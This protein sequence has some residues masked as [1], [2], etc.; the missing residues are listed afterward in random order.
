M[1]PPD[2]NEVMHCCEEYHRERVPFS[3]HGIGESMTLVFLFIVDI[4]TDRLVKVVSAKSFHYKVIL[5]PLVSI[6]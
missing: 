1:F 2:L 4:N 3:V 6:I 5:F